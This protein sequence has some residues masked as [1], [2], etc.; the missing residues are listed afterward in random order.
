ML[1]KSMKLFNRKKYRTSMRT[2]QHS[3]FS[4]LGLFYWCRSDYWSQ[5]RTKSI[6][7]LLYI[8]LR[9]VWGGPHVVNPSQIFEQ[10]L[11]LFFFSA[12]PTHRHLNSKLS[13]IFL[14][15]Y[16]HEQFK[17]PSKSY[18]R[19]LIRYLYNQLYHHQ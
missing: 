16:V 14:I 12:P 10:K 13:R 2:F 1:E 3:H 9:C 5:L 18:E 6:L 17:N 15:E 7:E 11:Y 4:L 19:I 8:F